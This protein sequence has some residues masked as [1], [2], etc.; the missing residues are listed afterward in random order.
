MSICGIDRA[1]LASP[2]AEPEVVE[3]RGPQSADGGAGLLQRQVGQLAGPVEL[4]GQRGT[5]VG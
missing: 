1:R 2:P 4:F 5:V 3:H